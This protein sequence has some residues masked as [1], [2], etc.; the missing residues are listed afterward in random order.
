MEQANNL[1]SVRNV[2]RIIQAAIEAAWRDWETYFK[3][4]K[5]NLILKTVVTTKG[6]VSELKIPLFKDV[7]KASGVELSGGYNLQT[8]A[9]QELE[10][11]ILREE[12]DLIAKD[13]A[14]IH[15][16]ILEAVDVIRQALKELQLSN[17]YSLSK[18]KISLDFVLTEEGKLKVLNFEFSRKQDLAHTVTI[19]ITNQ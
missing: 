15:A 9:T 6:G 7:A 4:N 17:G 8:V 16:S 3:V 11:E 18:A 2:I 10:L 1:G 12:V 14:D 13:A 5:I 19:E